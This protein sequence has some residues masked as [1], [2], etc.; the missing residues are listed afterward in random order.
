MVSLG[1]WGP[2]NFGTAKRTNWHNVG[3]LDQQSGTFMHEFGHNLNLRHGGR[4]NTN[5]KPNYASV[6]SYPLQFS[7]PVN[8]RP[9]DYSGRSSAFRSPPRRAW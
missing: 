6:M 1:S 5:C 9:L 7:N 3:T 8:P 4:D 2:F